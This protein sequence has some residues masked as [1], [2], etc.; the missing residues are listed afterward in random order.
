MPCD[1]RYRAWA[2]RQ[3][4][5]ADDM[6]QELCL[7]RLIRVT[8]CQDRPGYR[9]LKFDVGGA[10]WSWCFPGPAQAG[11]RS[12]QV[13]A[14]AFRPGAHGLVVQAVTGQGGG[15]TRTV[16]LDL[17]DAAE[18]AMSAVPVFL[19]RCLVRQQTGLVS[20][21]PQPVETGR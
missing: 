9:E 10:E 8:D 17:A 14:L 13:R 1:E 12:Q 16:M 15:L 2:M 19:H 21:V 7:A 3:A 20:P 18:L 5:T 4:H 6:P 11:R